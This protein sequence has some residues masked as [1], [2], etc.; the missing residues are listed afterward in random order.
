MKPPLLVAVARLIVPAMATPLLVE[1]TPGVWAAEMLTSA[2]KLRLTEVE[3]PRLM[4]SAAPAALLVSRTMLPPGPSALTSRLTPLP[5][6]A[7]KS[8]LPRV[9]TPAC[10]PMRPKTILPKVAPACRRAISVLSR[11]QFPVL[12][13]VNPQFTAREAVKGYRLRVP[14]PRVHVPKLKPPL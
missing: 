11:F 14:L 5:L 10:T 9:T 6:V 4:A 12:P 13:S 7:D 8:A 2:F 3:E 1:L